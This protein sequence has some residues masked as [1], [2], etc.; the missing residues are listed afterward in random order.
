MCDETLFK[1]QETGL[2]RRHFAAA[3]SAAVFAAYGAE[4]LAKGPALVEHMV[5]VPTPDGT[6]DAFFVHPARGK[7]PAV[8]LWPDIGG[9]REAKFAIARRLAAKGFAVL[10]V[11]HYYRGSRLPILGNFNEWRTPAGQEK[12]KPL[13][14]GVNAQTNMRDARA[15]VAWLD[16]QK[17]VDRKRG[18]GSQGYCMTGS[19]A[20]RT[21]AAVPDRVKAAASFHGGGM[22]GDRPESPNRVLGQ[23]RA[24]FLVAIARNDDAKAP[25]D[26]TAF[27][28]AAQAAGRPAEVE[29]YAADHGW[30]VPDSP[31]YNAAE[32]DRA[33]ARLLALYRSL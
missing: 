1:P 5:S 2:S 26:K 21:A 14:A 11:N 30:C 15:F 19:W 31:S 13:I 18:I 22:V 28:A 20:V 6:C 9:L 23:T 32:A 17:A 27:K 10:A 29:V 16:G 4:A 7:H 24:G 8:I 25:D 3:G 12:L 33:F